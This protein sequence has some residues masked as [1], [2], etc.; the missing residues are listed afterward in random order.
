MWVFI[1]AG[2][3]LSCM[4]QSGLGSLLLIAPTKVHP[5]WYTP[6]LPLLFLMSAIA[7]GFP[8]VVFE[9]TL[10]TTALKLEDEMEVLGPLSRFTIFT[11]GIYMALKLGD[12]FIRG[13]YV[14]LADGSVQGKAF[15]VEVLGG[16]IIPWIMLLFKKV[17]TKRALLFTG[18]TLIV[19]GVA[20]NRVN[21]FL[22]GFKA[23]YAQTSYLP[24]LGEMAITVGL[25]S[26]LIFLYRV[27]VNYLP[28]LSAGHAEVKS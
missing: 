14:Y 27:F 9:T 23:P 6:I 21:V 22:V 10:A 13:T 7:V 28:V 5:L 15:A 12:M 11:L 25:I 16:V 24:S 2:V 4:H 18:S 1:I 3:V 8:M 20:L 19:C 17:R 26:S